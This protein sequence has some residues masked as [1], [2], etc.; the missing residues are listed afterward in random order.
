VKS[1]RKVNKN[2]YILDEKEDPSNKCN[3]FLFNMIHQ[4]AGSIGLILGA[5]NISL[6]L[7]YAVLD[8]YW[9]VVWFIGLGVCVVLYG[10]LE[11]IN[12]LN[13]SEDV[14]K[15]T[16]MKELTDADSLNYSNISLSRESLHKAAP[17]KTPSQTQYS[18]QASPSAAPAVPSQPPQGIPQRYVQHLHQGQSNQRAESRQ[19]GTT[20]LNQPSTNVNSSYSF[21][22]VNNIS[23][24]NLN[25]LNKYQ[26]SRENLVNTINLKYYL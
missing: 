7:F 6:G 16:K 12:F 22:K 14:N 10:F 20:S 11:V 17:V 26:N 13:Y 19:T 2:D 18:Q 3:C 23:Q 5:I 1:R 8:W 9:L 24:S 15:D 4:N 21:G 25:K